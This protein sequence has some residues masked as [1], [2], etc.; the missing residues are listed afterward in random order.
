MA[1]HTKPCT[2]N[3]EGPGMVLFITLNA[4]SCCLATSGNTIVLVAVY[5][6]RSL[7]TISNFFICSLAMADLLVGFLN[8]PLYIAI[9]ALRVWVSDHP[10]YRA[11][12][13]VWIQALTITT[14]SLAVVSV[15]RYIA[16]TKV[17]RYQEILTQSRCAAIIFSIWAFSLII[18]SAAL[19]LDPKDGSKAWVSCQV[20]TISIPLVIMGYCYY[21]IYRTAQRQSREV[22]A[23]TVHAEINSANMANTREIAKNR[24]ASITVAIVIGLFI[25][26]LTPNFVF[27]IIEIS[28]TERCQNLKVYRHWLWAIWLGFTSSVFNPWV[29]AIRSREFRKA[30]RK[31]FVPIY[32]IMGSAGQEMSWQSRTNSN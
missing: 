31:I 23:T 25:I 3:L 27:S 9:V 5:K 22:H 12:N 18:G 17:F 20:I 19:F 8:N 29:Y 10:L 30:Y 16:I 32:Q 24:K 26:L 28:T 13:Y 1:N 6:T 14:F 2:A 15:D 4:F 11:E 7:R 21:H